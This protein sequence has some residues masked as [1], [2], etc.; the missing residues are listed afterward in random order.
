MRGYL[1]VIQKDSVTH[2]HSFAIYVKAAFAQDLSVE[3][4][5][6]SYLYF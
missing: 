6:D 3:N 2:I 4:P 5:E 1:P